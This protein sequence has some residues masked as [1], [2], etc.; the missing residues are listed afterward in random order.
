MLEKE[1]R[2]LY[3]EPQAAVRELTW[4]SETSKPS[5]IVISFLQ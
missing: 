1:L 5:P 2:V 4:A 3:L